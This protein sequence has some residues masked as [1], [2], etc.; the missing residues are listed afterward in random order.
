MPLLGAHNS[1]V[2]CAVVLRRI[3][4]NVVLL[5]LMGEFVERACVDRYGTRFSVWI[6]FCQTMFEG[7]SAVWERKNIAHGGPAK[8]H[9]PAFNRIV[10]DLGWHVDTPNV[11]HVA[12]PLLAEP[13]DM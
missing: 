13:A 7:V 6:C 11:Y 8:A 4:Y 5:D 3:D 12:N 9:D 10:A 2:H 1:D